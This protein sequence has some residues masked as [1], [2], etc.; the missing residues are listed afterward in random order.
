MKIGDAIEATIALDE[1]ARTVEVP[2][3]AAKALARAKLRKQFDALAFTH[4]KEH[5]DA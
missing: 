4:Q 1:A 5:V 3:D 2:E